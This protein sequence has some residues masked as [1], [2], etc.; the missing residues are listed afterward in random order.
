MDG[1]FGLASVFSFYN[2]PKGLLLRDLTP[3]LPWLRARERFP[4]RTLYG[5]DISFHMNEGKELILSASG[6][7]YDLSMSRKLQPACSWIYDK[8]RGRFER[9]KEFTEVTSGE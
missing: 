2:E 4:F 9:R 7:T 8:T 6:E 1:E 3:S 5:Q